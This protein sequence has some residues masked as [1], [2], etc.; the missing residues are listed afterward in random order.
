MKKR[1]VQMHEIANLLTALYFEN[2]LMNLCIRIRGA[3]GRYKSLLT[4]VLS[5]AHKA[6]TSIAKATAIPRAPS[7]AVIVYLLPVVR[8]LLL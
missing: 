1:S 5:T 3:K 4:E 7:C 6:K 8:P 2:L